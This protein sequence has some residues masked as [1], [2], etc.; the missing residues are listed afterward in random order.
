[1]VSY[2]FLSIVPPLLS[3]F[4]AIYTRNII[5]SLS[6]GAL[7][8]T[9]ILNSYNPFF[10]IVSLMRDHIFM[11]VSNPSNTQVI[12]ITLLI[13]GFVGLLEKSGGSKAF[14]TSIIRFVSSPQKGQLATWL[15]GISIFFSDTA[16]SLIV[17]PLFRPVFKELRIC[18]EKLAYIIDTTA[19]PVVILVPVASWGVYIMSLIDNSY[20]GMGIEADPYAV[21]LDV[22]PYQIYAFLALFSVPMI[23]STGKDFGSMAK[24]QKKYEKIEE[25]KIVAIIQEKNPSLIMIIL[26]FAIMI[27]VLSSVLGYYSIT[28]GVQSIHVNAGLCLSYVFASMGCAFVMKRYQ[29]KTY[30]QSMSVFFEGAGSLINVATVLALAW[31]LSSICNVIGTGPYLASL[32]GDNLNPAYFPIAV[33]LFGAMMSFATGSSYGTFA[34]LMATTLPVANILGA[35]L[36]LTI[37]AILSGGLFGDHTSPISDTTVLASMGANCPHIDHVSTQFPYAILTGIMTILAF[38]LIAIYQTPYMILIILL[39]QYISIR[40]IMLRWGS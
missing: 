24:A 12:I 29:G 21:L 34:I 22:W 18:R 35:D 25:K 40:L 23:I 3:V 28:E 8:G 26:P 19:S 15:S 32:I 11:Q 27:I 39:V 10:A 31:A 16:N 36:V 13:G 17:G 37:A 33:F 5:V 1:M 4:L 14:S 20:T 30:D 9:L 38:I 2:G 7:S 6:L